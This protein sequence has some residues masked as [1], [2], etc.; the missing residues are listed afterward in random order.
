M[1]PYEFVEIQEKAQNWPTL[2]RTFNLGRKNC[3]WRRDGFFDGE[4]SM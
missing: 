3:D 4:Y 2:M 1:V